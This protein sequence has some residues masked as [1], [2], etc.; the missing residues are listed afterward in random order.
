MRFVLA[1]VLAAGIA[2][3]GVTSAEA[4]SCTQGYACLWKDTSYGG[5][6][7]GNSINSGIFNMYTTGI[8]DVASSAWA[9]GKSCKYTTWYVND[10]T[11]YYFYLNSQTHFSSGY[12]DGNLS[13]G[14]GYGPYNTRNFDNQL[15]SYK[16]TACGW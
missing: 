16:F 5:T 11:G 13:N 1:G 4:A 14:A 15:S 10:Y 2:T 7:W 3:A 12:A 8:N 9:N 6:S